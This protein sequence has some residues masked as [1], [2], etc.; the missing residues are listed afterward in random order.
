MSHYREV[1]IVSFS[2]IVGLW[3]S[4]G[5]ISE[6][7]GASEEAVKKWRQRDNIPADFWETITL[8]AVRRKVEGVN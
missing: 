3:P 6:D 8:A 1:M 4:L 5:A 2:E 7:T